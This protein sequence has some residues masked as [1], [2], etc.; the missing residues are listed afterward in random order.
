LIQQIDIDIDESM[1]KYNENQIFREISCFQVENRTIKMKFLTEFYDDYKE[2]TLD[3]WSESTKVVE[4]LKEI[5][6]RIIGELRKEQKESVENSS[7]FNYLNSELTKEE[8]GSEIFAEKFYFQVRI[9][10]PDLKSWVFDLFTFVT[11]FYI[12]QSEIDLLE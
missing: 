5:R 3:K 6:M 9:K 8:K 10:R 12:S 7:R 2:E 11:D 4:Y 1:S